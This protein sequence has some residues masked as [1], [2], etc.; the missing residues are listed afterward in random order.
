M[1]ALE[2][3][4]LRSVEADVFSSVDQQRIRADETNTEEQCVVDG[5]VDD[6]HWF[7]LDVLGCW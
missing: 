7:K 5:S 6:D 3:R 1:P 2:G 4:T